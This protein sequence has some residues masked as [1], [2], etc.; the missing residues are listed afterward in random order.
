[1]RAVTGRRGPVDKARPRELALGGG[2]VQSGLWTVRCSCSGDS[3]WL[4]MPSDGFR[5]QCPGNSQCNRSS[6]LRTEVE[7]G[8]PA[9][10]GRLLVC[11]ARPSRAVTA[12]MRLPSTGAPTAY[13]TGSKNPNPCSCPTRYRKYT[14]FDQHM[15]LFQL[16]LLDKMLLEDMQ[17]SL[18]SP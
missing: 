13:V 6:N 10:S 18:T 1:M 9:G 7:R 11:S 2:R 14:L 12:R 3:R 15:R 8:A 17:M 5:G 4:L 16:F